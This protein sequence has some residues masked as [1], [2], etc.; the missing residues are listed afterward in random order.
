MKLKIAFLGAGSRD[1]GPAMLR[2]IYLSQPLARADVE[3]CLMDIVKENLA[4][5]ERYARHLGNSLSRR[6][7]VR[8]SDRMEAALEGANFVISA[9]EVRRYHHWAMDFHVP[10]RYGFR[11]IYGENG[12]PGGLFH[13]LRNMVPTSAIARA[14]ERLCPHATLLNFANPEQKL[15]EMLARTSK[16]RALGLCHGVFMGLGQAAHL[17]GLRQDEVV[18]A[19]CGINH[20][21]VFQSLHHRTTGEDLYP[22][23]REVEKTGDPLCDWHELALSR[24]LFRLYG[25]WPSPGTNHHGEYIRWANEF[26]A[27]EMHFYYDALD[28]AP[29]ETGRLPEF[30]YTIDRIDTRNRPI[31]RQPETRPD[32]FAAPMQPSGELAVPIIE[33]LGCGEERQLEAVIVPNRGAMPQLPDDMTV[34]VPAT[35]S[36]LGLVP[37]SMAPLPPGLVEMMRQQGTINRLLV[38][39]FTERSK[40]KLIQTVLLDPTVDSYRNAI[41]MVDE[42]LRLQR[43]VLPPFE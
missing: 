9:V 29:W 34:E 26:M 18:G 22:R 24:A 21:T 6:V 10:R 27:S 43:D 19:A 2:D 42:M 17:L 40:N 7:V 39:A 31:T 14:M 36:R 32:P 5:P 13:A 1:F 4:E 25:L 8:T 16:I 20:F 11:Q 30:V 41:A 35:A 15:C 37:M 12:G 23:L 33:A 3:L 28:G 38:E